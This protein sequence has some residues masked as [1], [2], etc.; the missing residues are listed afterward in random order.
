MYTFHTVLHDQGK[1]ATQL[2]PATL[3]V[4]PCLTKSCQ[5]TLVQDSPLQQKFKEVGVVGPNLYCH[6]AII[7]RQQVVKT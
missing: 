3:K 1:T 7:I 2:D 5:R 4:A 6:R